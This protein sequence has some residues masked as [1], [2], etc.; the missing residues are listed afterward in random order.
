M[1]E[2]STF[3]AE[4]GFSHLQELFVQIQFLRRTVA[5]LLLFHTLSSV[6]V[7]RVEWSVWRRYLL[8]CPIT[9]QLSRQNDS[10]HS[11]AT[12][13]A[14]LSVSKSF[15]YLLGPTFYIWKV[16]D[17]KGVWSNGR[18]W[19]RA[20]IY[21]SLVNPVTTEAAELLILLIPSY[22]LLTLLYQYI[23]RR[24]SN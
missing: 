11:Y 10:I 21:L 3:G 20:L 23:T 4:N 8:A 17:L 18:I 2:D 9:K 13:I 24:P 7:V 5:R 19:T 6:G 22:S 16:W 14:Y 1:L 12:A 15:S